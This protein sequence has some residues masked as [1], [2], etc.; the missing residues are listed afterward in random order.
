MT[1]PQSAIRNPAIFR[2]TG[3]RVRRAGAR[4]VLIR[5]EYGWGPWA[6]LGMV[7]VADWDIRISLEGGVLEAVHPCFQSGPLEE[8]RRD[9]ILDRSEQGVRVE[10]FTAR[11]QQLE[12]VPTKA[13]VLKA[14]GGPDTKLTVAIAI[15]VPGLA[16][17]ELQRTCRIGRDNFHW[18]FSQR[19]R[20]GPSPGFR[21]KLP[22]QL[23]RGGSGSWGTGE[24]V[25]PSGGRGERPDRLVEPGLGRG[26]PAALSNRPQQTAFRATR[27]RS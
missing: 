22:D 2:P 27:R 1:I 13:V 23:Q 17:P 19:V 26:S 25:L 14:R 9:R 16:H 7:Q 4:P 3:L 21:R 6:A 10:S 11:R 18:K 20:P 8:G 12:D 24:L 15:S 5:I